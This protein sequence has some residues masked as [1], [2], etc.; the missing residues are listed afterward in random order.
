MLLAADYT[1]GPDLVSRQPYASSQ[2]YITEHSYDERSMDDSDVQ[3]S[4]IQV[5]LG[6]PNQAL[7]PF[8]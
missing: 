4:A 5:S 2:T 8:A 3:E 6:M 7:R 1:T